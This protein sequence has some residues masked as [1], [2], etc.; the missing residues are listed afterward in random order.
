MSVGRWAVLKWWLA[1]WAPARPGAGWPCSSSPMMLSD[2]AGPARAPTQLQGAG[3]GAVG[4]A[5]GADAEGVAEGHGAQRDLAQVPLPPLLLHLQLHLAP[6]TSHQPRREQ[7]EGPGAGVA[8]TPLGPLCG[9]C[10]SCPVVGPPHL[11]QV[12]QIDPVQPRCPGGIE[13][14]AWVRSPAISLPLS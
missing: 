2:D 5:A 9:P 7:G 4:E 13:A 3:L 14:P 11:L 6:E 1:P 12:T 8:L 10:H